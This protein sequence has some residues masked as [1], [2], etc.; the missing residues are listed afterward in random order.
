MVCGAFPMK[1]T[2]YKVIRPIARVSLFL[3]STLGATLALAYYIGGGFW[4]S[5]VIIGSLVI[6]AMTSFFVLMAIKY[7]M[8]ILEAR[9][10]D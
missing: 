4:N 5:H 10:K 1:H 3:L 2:V 7:S 6:V 8:L 9:K